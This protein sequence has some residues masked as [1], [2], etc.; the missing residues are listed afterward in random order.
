MGVRLP[1]AERKEAILAASMALF[2]RHGFAGVTTRAIARAAG[3]SE[4]ILYRHF[5]GKESLYRAI[6]SRNLEQ[7]E[8]AMPVRL[9]AE[10]DAP[11]REYFR[12][13]ART[14]LARIDADPT[15]LRLLFHGALEDHPLAQAFEEARGARVRR[16]IERYLRRQAR[17]G[18]VRR[19]DYEV[20]A[21]SFVWL[22]VGFG[23]A[24]VLFREPGILRV[25]VD[26]LASRLT[27][28]FLLGLEPAGRRA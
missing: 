12:R 13:I 7:V 10:S 15:L 17:R 5:P 6:V 16:A 26:R 11:P 19:A 18:A 4:A 8:A 27:D 3:V 14:M 24:R 25:S 1:A 9:L 28:Q 23:L 20:A 22:V 21:R 2:A